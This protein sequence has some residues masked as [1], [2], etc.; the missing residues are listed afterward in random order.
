[1]NIDLSYRLALDPPEHFCRWKELQLLSVTSLLPSSCYSLTCFPKMLLH[2]AP[3]SPRDSISKGYFQMQ[4]ERGRKKNILPEDPGKCR[5]ADYFHLGPL[6]S[7]RP[8][9]PHCKG[10]GSWQSQRGRV[11]MKKCQNSVL[12]CSPWRKAMP[13]CVYLKVGGVMDAIPWI[14][15]KLL[16]SFCCVYLMCKASLSTKAGHLAG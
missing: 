9:G 5:L 16:V 15:G 1:M 10:L 2:R 11:S 14:S 4:Q 6:L 8:L 13:L 12:L 3:L 7:F